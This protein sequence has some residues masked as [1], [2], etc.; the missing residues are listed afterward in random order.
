MVHYKQL[1]LAAASMALLGT[2]TLTNNISAQ[3]Q[4]SSD[5]KGFEIAA[6]SDRS[7]RGFVN[8]VVELEMTLRNAAGQ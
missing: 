6:R 5:G 7:D 4:G 1:I 3:D 8:S 2:Y